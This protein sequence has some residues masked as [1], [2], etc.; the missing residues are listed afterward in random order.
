MEEY[1]VDTPVGEIVRWV[2]E[3][4]RREKPSLLIRATKEYAIESDFDREAFGI[5][6]DE[7]VD[8][9]SVHGV[10]EIQSRA[11]RKDW[12]LQLKVDD[13][14]GPRSSGE[15][16]GYDNDD[17]VSLAAFEEQFLSKGL[18]EVEIT[19]AAETSLAKARFD[20]WLARHL[21]ARRH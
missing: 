2:R 12:T 4:V 8:L 7:D 21:K 14:V 17:T 18:D 10:L 13:V 6:E 1:E 19:V 3:D 5:G 9:V 15:E 20:R 11:G 16:P